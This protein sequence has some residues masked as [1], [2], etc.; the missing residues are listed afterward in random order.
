MGE[1]PGRSDSFD[2]AKVPAEAWIRV[3]TGDLPCAR[4]R[5]NLRGLSILAVC[6]E[7]GTPVRGTILATVDPHAR[8]LMPIHAP[9]LTAAGLILWASCSLGAGLAVLTMRVDE[10]IAAIG[11]TAGP[12]DFQ[13]FRSVPALLVC[14]AGLGALCFVRPHGRISWLN[15]AAALLGVV[16]HYPLAYL[17]WQMMSVIDVYAPTPFT[18]VDPK[19][20]QA[21]SIARL[22]CAACMAIVILAVRPNGRL[23]VSRSILMR[24]GRVDRQTLLVILAAAGLAALGDVLRLGGPTIQNDATELMQGLGAILIAVGSLLM[25]LGLVGVF[26]D[27]LRLRYAITTRPLS[28]ESVLPQEP[29]APRAA[30]IP[31]AASG[32]SA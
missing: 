29:A 23:L 4:C 22:G 28:L 10:L 3:L 7:C 21:R 31:P 15:S 5:Y 20:S 2:S 12:H 13:T 19:W 14:L 16:A 25:L 30:P 8:E 9:W 27:A 32:R 26:I 1:V 18:S 24:T 6:P 11:W 17:L